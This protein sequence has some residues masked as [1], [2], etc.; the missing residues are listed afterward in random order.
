MSEM[1]QAKGVGVWTFCGAALHRPDNRLF[2]LIYQFDSFNPPMKTKKQS[3]VGL[4]R[5]LLSE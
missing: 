2:D 3:C 4:I 1:D 5:F